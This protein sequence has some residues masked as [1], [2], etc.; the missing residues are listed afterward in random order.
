[1][2]PLTQVVMAKGDMMNRPIGNQNQ[3]SLVSQNVQLYLRFAVQAN[4]LLLGFIPLLMARHLP[5]LDATQRR[6]FDQPPT[7]NQPQRQLFFALPD[8]ST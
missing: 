4:R 7:F 6:A 2:G 5:L 8:W 1:M 3:S